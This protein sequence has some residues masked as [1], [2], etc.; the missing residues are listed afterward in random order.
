LAIYISLNHKPTRLIATLMLMPTT[1]MTAE[2]KQIKITKYMN[3]NSDM[4]K[5][6]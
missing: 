4:L 1:V 5:Y 6:Y 3:S 2:I